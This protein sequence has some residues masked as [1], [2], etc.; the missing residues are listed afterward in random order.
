MHWYIILSREHNRGGS[1][2]AILRPNESKQV[3]SSFQLEFTTSDNWSSLKLYFFICNKKKEKFSPNSKS[4]GSITFPFPTSSSSR[5]FL[6]FLQ[7]GPKCVGHSNICQEKGPKT[8]YSYSI[9]LPKRDQLWLLT[10]F[11]GLIFFSQLEWNTVVLLSSPQ[12]RDWKFRNI[13]LLFFSGI[14]VSGNPTI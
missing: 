11:M 7:H 10:C 5:S 1:L 12:K 8:A 2:K 9:D 4:N 3:G 13:P 6:S 14:W